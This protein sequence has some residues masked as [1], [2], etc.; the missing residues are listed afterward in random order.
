MILMTEEETPRREPQKPKPDNPESGWDNPARIE[1]MQKNAGENVENK[2]V[3]PSA[4]KV[5]KK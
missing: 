3:T 5:V 2:Q 4:K 1:W